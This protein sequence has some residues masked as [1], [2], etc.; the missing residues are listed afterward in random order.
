[1]VALNTWKKFQEKNEQTATMVIEACRTIPKMHIPEKAS[2]EEN[3]QKF[4][5]G[6]NNARTKMAN[7]Q[8]ELNLKITELELKS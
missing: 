5:T 6:V 3:I 1:M 8:F 7:V 4:A 2:L